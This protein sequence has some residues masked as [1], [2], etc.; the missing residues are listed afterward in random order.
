MCQIDES[1]LRLNRDRGTA[2]ICDNQLAGLLSVIIPSNIT[3]S[4]NCPETKQAPA[5]YTK[6]GIYEKWIHSI[7]AINSPEHTV[8]GKPI[9]II[10]VS[11][12]YYSKP[13]FILF[14][15]NCIKFNTS[16]LLLDILTV[17]NAARPSKSSNLS[18]ILVIICSLLIHKI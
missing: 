10:P 17:T 15:C 3:N 11:P 9:P 1:Q 2:L 5:Y 18:L 4:T 6:V 8:D 13:I 14:S 16:F 7:I 12:P